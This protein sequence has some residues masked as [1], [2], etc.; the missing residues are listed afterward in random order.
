MTTARLDWERARERLAAARRALEA[1]SP[2]EERAV[3]AE[4]A[5]A[6]SRPLPDPLAGVADHDVVVFSVCGERF[7]VA[8]EDV[9]EAFELT[10]PTQVPG[11][12]ARLVGVVY[13]RGRVLAVMDLRETL[14]AGGGPAGE[15]RHVVAVQ[16]D[17]LAFG[18][19]AEAVEET[20][21][22]QAGALLTVLDLEAL[23]ADARLRIDDE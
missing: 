23:A 3:L 11:T 7:A 13:H 8:A 14:V 5:R 20:S 9:L 22:E 17:G 4:R 19:A 21:R 10:D 1:P 16:V 18:I 2:A 15:L 6:L 12:P